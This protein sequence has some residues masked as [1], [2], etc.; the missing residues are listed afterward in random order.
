M[1]AEVKTSAD[2]VSLYVCGVRVAE[3]S[4]RET[5][6]RLARLVNQGLKKQ[7]AMHT[8]SQGEWLCAE[9]T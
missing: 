8:R 2:H 3:G 4:D 5:A 6:E 7:H 1:I 9:P